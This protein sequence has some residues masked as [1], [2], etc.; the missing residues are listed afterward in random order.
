[1]LTEDTITT[2]ARHDLEKCFERF[3][4][5]PIL[6]GEDGWV[7]GGRQLS[8]NSM[9]L[10]VRRSWVQFQLWRSLLVVSELI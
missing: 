3:G 2:G 6:V 5:S 10:F 8:W 1:M 9:R 4:E 7:V